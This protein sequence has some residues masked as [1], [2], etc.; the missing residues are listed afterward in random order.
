MTG[1]KGQIWA[2]RIISGICV[3][4]LLFDA[5]MKLLRAAPVIEAQSRLQ[6]PGNLTVTIGILVLLCTVVYAIPRTAIF[7]AILMT[8][9]LGGAVAIQLRVAADLLS[10]L[11]PVIFATLLWGGL[12][13]RDSRLRAL[14]PLRRN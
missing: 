10:L 8:G 12:F 2:G 3:L 14:V 11:F 6:I 9:Y 7:G 5:L 13:L 1:S 4:F